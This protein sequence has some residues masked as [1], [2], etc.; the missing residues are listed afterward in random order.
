MPECA[1]LIQDTAKR[2]NIPEEE[3]SLHAEKYP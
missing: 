3:K 2:P 1:E